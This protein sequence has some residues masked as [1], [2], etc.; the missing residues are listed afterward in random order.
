MPVIGAHRWHGGH[1]FAVK[2]RGR[3][4]EP[5]VCRSRSWPSSADLDG[6]VAVAAFQD[7]LAEHARSAYRQLHETTWSRADLW[8]P[9]PTIGSPIGMGLR[10]YRTGRRPVGVW[11]DHL[12]A[13]WRATLEAH[14]D[15]G[16]GMS[17]AELHR[18]AVAR[19]QRCRADQVPYIVSPRLLSELVGDRVRRAA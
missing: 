5:L 12:Y 10:L 11:R 19:G 7:A 17:L 1:A 6:K 4:M 3:L 14:L 2:T 18:T 9:L 16:D 8:P 15:A 13:A